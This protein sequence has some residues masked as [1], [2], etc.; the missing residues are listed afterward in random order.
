VESKDNARCYE[1]RTTLEVD[2]IGHGH[3]GHLRK[4][5]RH[6]ARENVG[7]FGLHVSEI[8][9]AIH[10]R[11]QCTDRHMDR[12]KTETDQCDEAAYALCVIQPNNNSKWQL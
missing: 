4:T 5:L 2:R 9:G 12:M 8:R 7:S 1:H 10:A 6:G 3:R 11:Q